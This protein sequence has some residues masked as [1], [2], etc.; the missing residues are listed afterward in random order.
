[1]V[2]AAGRAASAAAWRAIRSGPS[3][4]RSSTCPLREAAARR[5]VRLTIVPW[6]CPSIAACGASTKLVSPSDSQW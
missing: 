4:R 1:M 2:G 6:Q 3:E 5:S